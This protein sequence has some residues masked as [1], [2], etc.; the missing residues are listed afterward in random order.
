MMHALFIFMREAP[1]DRPPNLDEICAENEGLQ[2]VCPGTNIA[3]KLDGQFSLHS[4]NN[5][6]EGIE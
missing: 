3:V 6:K 4:F 1:Q 2:N 5:T